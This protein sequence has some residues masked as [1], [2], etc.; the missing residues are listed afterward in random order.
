MYHH[1][2]IHSPAEGHLGSFQ[3]WAVM[4]FCYCCLVAQSCPTL[5]TH[6]L[7]HTRLSRPS[8]SPRACSNSYPLSQWRHPTISSSVAPFSFCLQ[9]FSASNSFPMSWFFL[10]CYLYPN[11]CHHGILATH[12][13]FS[14]WLLVGPAS[15]LCWLGR[16]P[17]ISLTY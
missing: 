15:Q 5:C 1:L 8:P 17:T 16:I 2:F 4:N 7:Q 11:S 14:D 9:S 6:K 3:V 13:R 10:F 12:G